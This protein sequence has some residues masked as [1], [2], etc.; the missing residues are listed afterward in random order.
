MRVRTK[1]NG[2]SVHAVAG[3][4][5]VLLGLDANATARDGL[6]GFA[7]HRNDHTNKEQ[8]WARG[9]RIFKANEGHAA[10]GVGSG[11][12]TW[13]NPV[14]TFLWSDYTARPGHKYTYRVVPVYGSPTELERAE[15]LE[16][17]V[18]TEPVTDGT[19]AVY[20]NRGVAGSQAYIRRF[21]DKSPDEIGQAAYT[22]LSRG[23]EEALIDYIGQAEKGDAL[24]AA[25]YEFSYAPVLEAFRKAA[26]RGVD[27]RIVFDAREKWDKK[28]DKPAGPFEANRKAVRE[29]GITKYCIERTESRSYI[30]HNK[31][32]VVLRGKKKKPEQVWTG[33][34]NITTG[35]IFGHSNV[36]H[37]VRDEAVAAAY[38]NYW[39]QLATDPAAPELR[40]WNDENSPVPARLPRNGIV[41]IFSPRPSLEALDNYAGYLGGAE[42]CTCLTLAFTLSKPFAAALAERGEGLNY[43]LFDTEPKNFASD[44]RSD[45]RLAIG[46]K[47]GD[48]QLENWYANLWEKERLTGLNVHVKY[49]HTK[50]L[51]VDPFAANPLLVTGSANFSDAS[52]RNNDENMLI[53]RGDT[54]VVDIY[55]TEFMRIFAHYRARDFGGEDDG[56][57]NYLADTD[58]WTKSFFR[59]GHPQNRQREIFA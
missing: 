53:I 37:V 23:L 16:V 58:R 42:S 49:L 47:L 55:L 1:K 32:I 54:R 8:H 20:F 15:P 22:W 43:L 52:T 27:I 11:V 26:K 28:N 56:A 3:S 48:D 46:A 33:S 36:G 44:G 18:T 4:N 34:T 31:F 2:V 51:I 30:S 45:L 21:G 13:T 39:E 6:L 50:Y 40:A 41:P 12:S 24:R 19:H 35:G 57:V 10:P 17:T 14:Q 5:V 7:V 9:F 29:A 38:L 25:V 59:P